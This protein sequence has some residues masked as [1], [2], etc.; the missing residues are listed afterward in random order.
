MDPIKVL[1][2]CQRKKSY[3]YKETIT[4]MT[5]ALMVDMTV[6]N[7]EKYLF[8]YY[9]TNDIIIEYLVEHTSK[10]LY[11]AD[12]NMWF[13]PNSKKTDICLQSYEFIKNHR[14]MYDMVMLQTCPLMYFK[15]N[16]KHLPLIMKDSGVLTIKAFTHYDE[17]IIIS[18]EKLIPDV[19]NELSKY[20]EYKD[21]VYKLLTKMD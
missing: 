10:D 16:F 15:Q 7:I 20:F 11:E 18:P 12:Y 19:Y 3:D 6:K 9:G 2:M 8:E 14:D 13:E 5:N 17:A 4:N 1:V 21:D